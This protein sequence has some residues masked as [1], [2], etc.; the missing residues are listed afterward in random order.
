[1]VRGPRS[2]GQELAGPVQ[3]GLGLK[4][5][6]LLRQK[7]IVANQIFKG[8]TPFNR[9]VVLGPWAYIVSPINSLGGIFIWVF[10][11]V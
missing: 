8:R 1:M 7:V 9:P 3:I 4:C 10:A 6:W 11:E 2:S 5:G